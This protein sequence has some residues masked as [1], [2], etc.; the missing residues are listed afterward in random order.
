MNRKITLG[1]GTLLVF[2]LLF[3]AVIILANTLLRGVRLDLTENNLYTVAPGT[4]NILKN[5]P[6]PVTLR[7]FVSERSVAQAP[8]LKTY[9]NR[10]RDFLEELRAR[11]D[12]KLRLEVIDPQPFSEDEDRAAELGIRAIP[13][14]A[15]GDNLYFGLA[16]SNST[17]GRAVIDFFD[18]S[19]EEFLE[20][21][22]A[23]L[24]Y[25]LGTPKKPVVGWLSSLPMN[26]GM[27]PMT[28]Q[29]QEPWFV[30]MQAQELFT[31]RDLEPTLT[32]VDDDVDVLVI[33]HPKNLP[34]SALFAIDQFALRGGRILAFVDPDSSQDQAAQDPNNPM[35]AMTA[36]RSSTLGPLFAA[37]GL[38]FNPNEVVVDQERGL[39]V[40]M[41]PGEPP[42]R[43]IG[44]LGLD[45]TSLSKDI[46]TAGLTSINMATVGALAHAKGAKTKFEPL[47]QSS[48]QA[49]VLPGERFMAL[50]DPS[51]L[52]DGFKA[53]GVQYALAA[54]VT[55][56]VATAFPNGVASANT[57]KALKASV[58]PLNVIVFADTDMLA[59]YLW[60]QQ[61]NFFGQRM[62]QAIANNG[63]VTWNAIDNLA[64]SNDLISVRGRAAFTRPFDR[65]D[66]LRRNADDRLR[67]K[68]QELEQQLSQTEERLTAL[69]S[70]RSAG[71]GAILT[72]EQQTEIERFQ[73]EKLR[74]RKELR[75]VRLGLEQDI[76]SLGTRLKLINILVVP[77][78]LT[79]LALVVAGYRRRRS[80]A[81]LMLQREKAA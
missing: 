65:V 71:S 69:E 67:A 38:A 52:R 72:P 12:G 44:I 74:I 40:G 13:T 78:V 54:R 22:I 24:I 19:K 75:E 2:G 5:L 50:L 29:P 26:G 18:P 58:K 7:L 47:L 73:Q 76:K 8:A 79:V 4:K 30:R 48:T 1:T 28:G 56:N 35:A 25:Q 81:I 14:N 32:Q 43:H 41:R 20:Y 49:G 34:E 23:K 33:V 17:D 11:S 37:W 16:G 66:A 59:D 42:V 45:A 70:A 63:D 31:L 3:V 51:T 55:G 77:L 46:V 15:A 39:Q 61:R 53:T 27:D 80:A 64:G 9:S 68:E 57:E 21:D 62:A 10:V 36:Q 6:E 60:L